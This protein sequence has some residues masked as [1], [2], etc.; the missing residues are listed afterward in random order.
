MQ[1]LAEMSN[2]YTFVKPFNTGFWVTANN[3][4]SQPHSMIM[5][6][7]G[8]PEHLSNFSNFDRPHS[9]GLAIYRKTLCQDTFK[10][11]IKVN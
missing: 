5:I 3:L 2:L 1:L 7:Y 4:V 8:N 6:K 9:T 11:V 10:I